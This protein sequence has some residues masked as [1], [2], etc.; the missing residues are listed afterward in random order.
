MR[1]FY[2]LPVKLLQ[3]NAEAVKKTSFLIIETDYL[4][5]SLKLQTS[6][7]EVFLLIKPCVGLART[8]R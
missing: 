1:T 8:I 2:I 4:Y 5:A 3:Y 7:N 6:M